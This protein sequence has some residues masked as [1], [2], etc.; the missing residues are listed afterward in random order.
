MKWTDEELEFLKSHKDMKNADIAR[1]L[2]RT[3][4]A[5][6]KKRYDTRTIDDIEMALP[7]K[8]TQYE[9]E[10][11]LI[12]MAADMRVKLKGWNEA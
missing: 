11:R 2:G 9:K 5:V 6:R 3:E 10:S 8:L 12:K 7:E 4:M 1:T